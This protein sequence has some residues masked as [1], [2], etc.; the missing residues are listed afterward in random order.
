MIGE[1]VPENKAI[2]TLNDKALAAPM[3][4]MLRYS[5]SMTSC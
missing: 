3:R 2:L 5:N 1:L 4:V